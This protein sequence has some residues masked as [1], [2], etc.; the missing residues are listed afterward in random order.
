QGLIETSDLE[1]LR[2]FARERAAS[3]ELPRELRPKNAYNLLRLLIT[4]E[5]WLRTGEPRF[6]IE[7]GPTRDRLLAIKHGEV[8]L[9]DV[10]A[11]AEVLAPALEVARD[12]SPL[13]ARPDVRR[14]DALLRRVGE[15]LARRWIERAP[16]PF[17]ADA[18]APPE[19]V[20]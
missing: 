8:A 19:V 15:E 6:E 16:G 18:P 2:R 13:P 1:A 14:A 10:L 17:G 12:A 3:L 4:A 20:W 5:R 11:E 7:P 9:E